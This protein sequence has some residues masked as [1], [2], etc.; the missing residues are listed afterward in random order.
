MLEPNEV[1]LMGIE[2]KISDGI[3]TGLSINE[4]CK[5]KEL[6]V[7]PTGVKVDNNV[8]CVVVCADG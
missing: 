3:V 7:E 6:T 1:S 5:I 4:H 8:C 2:S